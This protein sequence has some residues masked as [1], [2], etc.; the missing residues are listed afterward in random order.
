MVQ[1]RKL[2]TFQNFTI[3]KTIKS[4]KKNNF[5]NSNNFQNFTISEI[6]RFPLSTK[7]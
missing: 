5:A 6:I 2:A 1:F 7:S 4:L 3:W